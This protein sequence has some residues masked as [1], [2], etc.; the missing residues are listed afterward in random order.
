MALQR[1]VEF[2]LVLN[3]EKYHFMVK[4]GIMLGH[5]IFEKG[6]EVDQ[7]KVEV[8]EKLTP[9]ISVKEVHSFLGHVG[10]YWRFIKDFSNIG[11]LLCK[12]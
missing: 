10:F 7:A 2:N 11:N 5:K 8:I 6:I 4:K 3:W 9:P 1:Y 12:L